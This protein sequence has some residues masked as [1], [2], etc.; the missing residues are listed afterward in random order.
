[1]FHSNTEQLIDYWRQRRGAEQTPARA[2]INPVDFAELLPQVFMLGREGPGRYRV[3]LAGGFIADLHGRELR[4]A[5]FLR[6]WDPSARTAL[7]LALEAV[8]RHP[9][10]LVIQ[11]DARAGEGLMRL[12]VLVAPLR[13]PSGQIDR[14]I[15]LYQPVTPATALKGGVVR[16]F[17]IRGI[18]T[19]AQAREPFPRLRLASVDG[20]HMA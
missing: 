5:D 7:Q 8:R 3:R 12:E 13:G 2:A 4:Y 17:V 11:A 10:P 20:R 9:E 19:T 16:S 15:G 14:M 18:S 6:L 1:M